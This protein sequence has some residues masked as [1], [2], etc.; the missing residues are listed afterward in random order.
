MPTAIRS[1]PRSAADCSAWAWRGPAAHGRT[2][3]GFGRDA[4]I[5]FTV[6][7]AVARSFD[8]HAGLTATLPVIGDIAAA[9]GADTWGEFGAR[10]ETRLTEQLALDVDFNG[11]TGGGPLGTVL[12]GGVGVVLRF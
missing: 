10:I 1:R 9:N 7:G 4:P 2:I 11:T 6:A 3:F 8:V 12:H 5:S